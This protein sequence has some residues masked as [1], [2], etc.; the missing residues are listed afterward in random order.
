MISVTIQARAPHI[1]TLSAPELQQHLEDCLRAR[2]K[3]VDGQPVIF[4]KV[5][6][7]Q[8][9]QLTPSVVQGWVQSMLF[10]TSPNVNKYH[11]PQG[12]D[13]IWLGNKCNPTYPTSS[14]LASNKPK[15]TAL[16]IKRF[17][18]FNPD[19]ESLEYHCKSCISSL[20]LRAS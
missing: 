16:T 1:A 18:V 3:V 8:Y 6:S 13:Y 5:N 11:P 4:R 19:P 2:A 17:L 9:I 15:P 12:H 10:Q 7:H 14:N 20:L